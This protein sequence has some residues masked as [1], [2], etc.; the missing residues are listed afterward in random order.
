M[1]PNEI[2]DLDPDS[3]VGMVSDWES[4][5]LD[6]VVE[7]QNFDVNRVA[8]HLDLDLEIDIP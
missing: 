3:G 4:E 8:L 7:V 2:P 1:T 6:R 5:L